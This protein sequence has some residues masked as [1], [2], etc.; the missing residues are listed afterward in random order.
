[1][2]VLTD[3]VVGTAEE[4]AALP[5]GESPV[6]R[7]GGIDIKGIDVV[8]L[9]VLHSLATGQEFDPGLDSFPMVVGEESPDGPWVLAFPSEL[10]KA[11]VAL[12]AEATRSLGTRWAAA[13][14]FQ[15][16][17]WPEK[18]VQA[19]LSRIREVAARAIA[20]AKPIHVW[21]SL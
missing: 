15:L 14:E 19:V 10:A 18:D 11:L 4:I 9:G 2:G 5:S 20:Q 13:E 3:L 21:T 6:G 12:D 17:E 16:D 7:L 1:M 8:K